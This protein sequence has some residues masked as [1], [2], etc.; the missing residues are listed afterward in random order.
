MMA[1]ILLVFV[2]LPIAELVLLLKVG[3]WIGLWRTVAIILMTAIVGASMWRSQGASVLGAIQNRLSEN[4]MPARELLEGVLVLL[5]GAFFVTPGFITDTVG[6]VCLIP[7]T[8]TILLNMLA[9]WLKRQVE[10]GNVQVYVSGL[11]IGPWNDH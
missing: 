5:G 10:Q 3:A 4:E 2:G 11:S 9:R 1:W 7:G 6:F 8:R